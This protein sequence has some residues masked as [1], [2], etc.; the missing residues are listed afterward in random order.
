MNYTLL[1]QLLDCLLPVLVHV[2]TR[3]GLIASLLLCL[4]RALTH[5]LL[6]PVGTAVLA[7]HYSG[8]VDWTVSSEQR[9]PDSLEFHE[10][11]IVFKGTSQILDQEVSLHRVMLRTLEFRGHHQ[12]ECGRILIKGVLEHS[13]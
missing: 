5:L 3:R 6:P 11:F 4:Q 9:Y 8:L 7:H 1:N 2:H 10:L 12:G 13:G